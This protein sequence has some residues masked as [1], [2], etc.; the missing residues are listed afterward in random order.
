[1]PADAMLQS[2][3]TRLSRDLAK[4][5]LALALG[6]LVVAGLFA[7]AVV[8][9]RTPPFDRYVTDPQFF[10][11]CL[12]A[13]VN[14]A[15][16]VWFY[17]FMSALLFLMPSARQP[18]RSARASAGVAASGVLLMLVG[19][20]QL[21][22]RPLLSNYIPTIENALFQWGQ[23]VFAVGV[24]LGVLD[25]RLLAGAGASQGA[26]AFPAAVRTGLSA[27]AISILI[28]AATLGLTF[29]TR[30]TEVPVEVR[31][32]FLMW[33]VGHVLQL[34]SSVAMV[35]MWLF[36]LEP[37]LGVPPVSPS[38][39]TT[40]FAALVAPWCMALVFALQGTGSIAYRHGFT[41]LMRW[42]LFPVV[43]VFLVL[44]LGA[45]LRA[46]RS[47]RLERAD[48]AQPRVTAFLV[49]AA[50]TLLGFGLGAMIRGSNTMVPSHYHAS[51]GA[52]TVAFMA[53]TFV[54][55]PAFHMAI[56][57]GWL[58]RAA[59]WQSALYGLG[60][61]VFAA[62]FAIAGAHG[63]GR[64]LY[65]A[66]QATRG[67]AATLGLG[68]MGVGGFVAIAGGL[69]FLALVAASWWSSKHGARQDASTHSRSSV[70]V[71]T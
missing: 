56:P 11:R 39:A 28:A 13:H 21:S 3:T 5:W 66:E 23:I 70:E 67:F 4:Q 6:V 29:L 54:I 36:L 30:T 48:L 69:L 52:V 63:M 60:M 19:T 34:V 58:A 25:R 41:F 71:T 27:V 26:V 43:G 7:L 38:A 61:L 10:K 18:S 31:S 53:A 12:V 65:G 50:L 14:L 46:L 68:L 8:L 37:A 47:G 22:G 1:M 45:L 17:A 20:A 15:L 2:D 24:L 33:G 59:P 32:E 40:L 62:G 49:S 9:G 44:C 55:L 42:G 64:K 35:T 57:R 16:V 51:V